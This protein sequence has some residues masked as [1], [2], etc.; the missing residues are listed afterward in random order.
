MISEPL[1]S[2]QDRFTYNYFESD[3]D[4]QDAEARVIVKVLIVDD[5]V[6]NLKVMEE[7]LRNEPYEILTAVSGRAALKL[8]LRHDFALIFMDVRMPIMDGLE[9]ARIIRERQR[10]ADVPIM[11]LTAYAREDARQIVQ[12]Y[13]LG[14]VDYLVKPV[15][16]EILRSKAAAF[17]E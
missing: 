3:E 11:F 15:A 9:T 2:L 13:S 14:A 12:G 1:S 5:N 17:A 7:V 6:G 4:G 16:P 10:S 8:I